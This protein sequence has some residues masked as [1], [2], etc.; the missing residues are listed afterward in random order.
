MRAKFLCLI[1]VALLSAGSPLLSGE[2]QTGADVLK[3][4][5]GTWRFASVDMGGKPLPKEEATKRTITFVG[6]KWT[7]HEGDKILQAG[8]HKFDPSYKPGQVDAMVTDGE[9]KGN[10]MLGIY[11]MKGDNTM[12]VCFDPEGKERP[13]SFT[14]KEGQF[15]A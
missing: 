12:Q 14:A 5:Q 6:D 15:A 7:V 10:K 1:A 11:E 9:G 8:T 4:L 2:K 3:H 13:T